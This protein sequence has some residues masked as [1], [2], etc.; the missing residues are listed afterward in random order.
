MDRRTRELIAREKRAQT[1]LLR[2]YGEAIGQVQR[3]LSVVLYDIE[4]AKTQGV[5]PD[6]RWLRKQASYERWLT[7]T[8]LELARYV[9]Q[10]A[11]TITDL[12]RGHIGQ[13]IDDAHA[14]IRAGFQGPPALVGTV[15]AE[16]TV[17]PASV[18]RTLVGN[19]MDGTPLADLLTEAA[20]V[21]HEAARQTLLTGVIRGHGPRKIARDLTANT[22]IGAHRSLLIARTESIGAYRTTA[23]ESYRANSQVVGSWIW[24]CTFDRRTCAAC[25]A[26]AGTE[27]SLDELLNSH[28]GCRCTPVPRTKSWQ[29]L[30]I[31]LPD[32]RPAVV[33]GVDRFAGLDEAD[34]LAVLG[35]GKLEAYNA[36]HLSLT[37]LVQPTHSHRWG[38]GMREASLTEALAH[39]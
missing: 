20:G 38:P 30:G 10:A 16:F 27:H 12:Q 28:P 35:R 8:R 17:P 7:L 33:T 4:A 15:T 24:T 22:Q 32:N 5:V 31:D 6:A 2:Y 39:H 37:D 34:K 19:A 13:S 36:G 11:V 18:I 14:L 26:M 25:W 23:I 3:E 1:D 21:A 29:D 9:Q